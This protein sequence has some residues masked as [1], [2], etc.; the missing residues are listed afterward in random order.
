MILFA[1]TLNNC[2]FKFNDVAF[3]WTLPAVLLSSSALILY[4]IYKFGW[5][6]TNLQCEK[7]KFKSRKQLLIAHKNGFSGNS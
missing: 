4:F 1:N 5:L 3:I 7:R 6:K 2:Y